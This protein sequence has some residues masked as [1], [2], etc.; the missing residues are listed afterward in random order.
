M[1]VR[2][3][4]LN[5]SGPPHRVLELSGVS[6]VIEMIDGRSPSSACR[7]GRPQRVTTQGGR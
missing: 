2:L 3:A 4:I 6:Q 5:G 7:R 1:K